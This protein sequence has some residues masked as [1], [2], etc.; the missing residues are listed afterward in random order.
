MRALRLLV[1]YPDSLMWD[2]PGV[3]LQPSIRLEVASQGSQTGEADLEL[4]LEGQPRDNALGFIV[5][6]AGTYR[7]GVVSKEET[8]AKA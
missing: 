7:A 2:C 6:A 1:T 5:E 8:E 4:H 3:E